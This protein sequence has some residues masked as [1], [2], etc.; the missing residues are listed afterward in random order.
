MSTIKVDNI[1][2]K[3]G[4]GLKVQGT[5]SIGNDTNVYVAGT[6]GAK[7][8]G[9]RGVTMFAGDIVTSGAMFVG[10]KDSTTVNASELSFYVTGTSTTMEPGLVFPTSGISNIGGDLVVSGVIRGG[11]MNTNSGPTV[12]YDLMMY[13]DTAMQHARTHWFVSQHFAITEAPA[14]DMTF[15]VSGSKNS[16]DTGNPAEAGTAVFGGDVVVS[17]SIYGKQ[18][19]MISFGA[20]VGTTALHYVDFFDA[21][22]AATSFSDERHQMIAMAQGVV[23]LIGVRLT[24]GGPGSGTTNVKLIQDTPPDNASA[25]AGNTILWSQVDTPADDLNST[26]PGPMAGFIQAGNVWGITIEN[27]TQAPEKVN[28]SLV[29]EWDFRE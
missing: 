9:A 7:F 17:G 1:E 26:E 22:G 5:E 27:S 16:K 21:D 20:N 8:T 4:S 18:K 15:F 14:T 11:M 10:L 2:D 23:K 12:D 3:S 19:Q 29:V 24:S 25:A 6:R 13:G 28:I